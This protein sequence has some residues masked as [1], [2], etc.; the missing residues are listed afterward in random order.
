MKRKIIIISL[1]IFFI[2]ASLFAQDPYGVYVRFVNSSTGTDWTDISSI[3][4]EVELDPSSGDI[5][6]GPSDLCF[7]NIEDVGA[8]VPHSFVVFNLANFAVPYTPTSQIR[9]TIWD[10]NKITDSGETVYDLVDFKPANGFMGWTE[11][12]D[13]GGNPLIIEPDLEKV[14][15]EKVFIEEKQEKTE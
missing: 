6:S 8:G 9:V 1:F 3:S 10:G 13:I 12:F 7:V 14:V 4:F 11:W 2:A 15:E 5:Q